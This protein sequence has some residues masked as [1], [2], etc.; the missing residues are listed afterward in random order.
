[1]PARSVGPPQPERPS[2]WH[3]RRSLIEE[4]PPA[5]PG[6]PLARRRSPDMPERHQFWAYRDFQSPTDPRWPSVVAGSPSPPV[7]LELLPEEQAD[8]LRVF[9]PRF[10]CELG[11]SLSRPLQLVVTDRR[12][13]FLLADVAEVEVPEWIGP[14]QKLRADLQLASQRSRNA[15]S[16]RSLVAQMSFSDLYLVKLWLG[17]Q[18]R[19][20]SFSLTFGSA[21]YDYRVT[22]QAV[23]LNS[24][25]EDWRFPFGVAKTTF[26][27]VLYWR[28]TNLDLSES[29]RQVL[30]DQYEALLAPGEASI[31]WTMHRG[32]RLYSLDY[33][34]PLPFPTS[35]RT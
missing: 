25:T 5:T 14:V 8:A 17:E 7:A 18:R 9:G 33:L 26:C 32:K 29:D 31:P 12:V 3:L 34:I 6:W 4:Q 30:S 2:S 1:M 13:A 11:S 22:P 16:G 27:R 23:E 35:R 15:K 28:L 19:G 21:S 20:W 24:S 10:S